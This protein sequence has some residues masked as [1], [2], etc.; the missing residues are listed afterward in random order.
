MCVVYLYML[1]NMYGLLYLYIDERIDIS[2]MH[3]ISTIT[4][5]IDR[6]YT[7]HSVYDINTMCAH[8]CYIMHTVHIPVVYVV[9]TKVHVEFHIA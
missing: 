1:H 7:T 2:T 4:Y 9:F 5:S 8:T 3:T 6:I